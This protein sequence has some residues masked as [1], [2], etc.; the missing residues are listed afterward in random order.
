MDMEVVKM[1]IKTQR[2]LLK[3]IDEPVQTAFCLGKSLL[4]GMLGEEGAIFAAEF[5]AYAAERDNVDA[6][7]ELGMCYR[8]GEGGVLA[9]ADKAL[10]W[11]GK[12]AEKGHEQAKAV[13]D[14]FSDDQGKMVLIMSA[15]SGAEGQGTKWYKTKVGVEGYYDLAKSG[16][17]E[18][19]YELARRLADPKMLGEFSHNIE[20]AVYWYTQAANQGV[21]DAMFNLALIYKNGTLGI[22]PDLDMAKHWFGKAALAGDAEAKSILEKMNG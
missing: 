7:Y 9:D 5:F 14:T 21:V 6:M 4:G 22:T 1:T 3:Q 16:N 12:A 17:A 11:L 10:H 20:E 13:Y 18:V 19:Q 15:M 2:E 8:W